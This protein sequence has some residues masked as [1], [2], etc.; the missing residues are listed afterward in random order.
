MAKNIRILIVCTGNICRS[1]MAE[2]LFRKL[3][4][5][6]GLHDRVVVESAGTFAPE[7]APASPEGVEVAAREGIDLRGHASRALS[8]RLV[9]RADRI[10]VMEPEHRERLIAAFPEAEEKTFLLTTFADPQ[11]DPLGVID[12]IGMGVE[13]YERVYRQIEQALRAALP[14][15]ERLANGQEE[16]PQRDGRPDGRDRA[17]SDSERANR[18]AG[19]ERASRAEGEEEFDRRGETGDGRG[20]G[21]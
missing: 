8:T 20:A 10:L 15:I 7:G 6:A 9:S 1:P 12:P 16:Q 2:G 11:G 17:G 5:E 19:A 4:R 21:R 13:V 14:E 18:A 3:V